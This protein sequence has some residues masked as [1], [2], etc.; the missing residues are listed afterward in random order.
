MASLLETGWNRIPRL[1]RAARDPQ[2]LLEIR[3]PYK[4][5]HSAAQHVL[6]PL[7]SNPPP[8]PAPSRP[9]SWVESNFPWPTGSAGRLSTGEGSGERR[10]SEVWEGPESRGYFHLAPAAHPSRLPSFRK[11]ENRLCGPTTPPGCLPSPEAT[12]PSGTPCSLFSGQ[13]RGS[14]SELA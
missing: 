4:S 13:R 3:S 2:R 11:T 12:R 1:P 5:Q 10:G 6:R 7:P 8:T 14:A 9:G